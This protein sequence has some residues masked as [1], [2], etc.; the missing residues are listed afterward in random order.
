MP[1]LVHAAQRVFGSWGAAV[2]AAGFDYSKIR[3]YRKWSR[4]R[5]LERIRMHHAKGEDLSWRNVAYTLDPALAA[6][7]LREGRFDSWAEAL[8]TAGLVPEKVARYRRWSLDLVQ[9]EL[10]MLLR[11]GVSL[12]QMTLQRQA[13]GLLAAVYRIGG[14]L[15]AQ[16]SVLEARLQ[17]QSVVLRRRISA[18]RRRVDELESA[19]A[20]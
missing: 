15:E 17:M 2:E 18:E 11:Q 10:A 5:V 4:E 13:P 19:K 3:R 7:A 8:R 9:K 20:G 14:S 16:R 6:A 1:S 12:D